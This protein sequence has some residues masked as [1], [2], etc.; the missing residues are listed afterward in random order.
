MSRGEFQL[1]MGLTHQCAGPD[2]A[3]RL[4]HDVAGLDGYAEVQAKL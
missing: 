1:R 3:D 2:G 4:A